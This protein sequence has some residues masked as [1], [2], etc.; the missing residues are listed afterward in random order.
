M[1]A[2]VRRWLCGRLDAALER[3]IDRVAG[4]ADVAAV[5]VM[6]DVHQ[7]RTVP[8]GVVVATR[9]LVYPDLVG[10]DIGCGL[11]AIRFR[12]AAA[13]MDREALEPL[14]D[15]LLTAVP[16]LK[17]AP[18]RAE[19]NRAALGQ[20]GSLS[21]DRLDRAA[22]RDG[23]Y[24][25]GTLGRGNHF[26]ELARGD[27]G[28]LWAVVHTGS[29]A[30]GQEITAHHLAR[31]AAAGGGDTARGAD[32]PPPLPAL[33]LDTPAGRDYFADMQWAC[34]YAAAN[35]A[36]I[37]NAV[38]DLL[39]GS[40][41]I[42]VEPESFVDSPHNTATAEE[43]A[44]EPLVVHRKS[45]NHAA[46]GRAGIVAGSMAIGSRITV[47]LGH[48]AA[49]ASSAHGAGRV[50]S[51]SV[52]AERVPARDL[53]SRMR[54][55]VFRR[56]WAA[57]LRDETPQAYRELHEVMQAQHELVRTVAVLVPILNDKRP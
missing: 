25:L 27:D 5:A 53:E 32:S 52:A 49:L 17:H 47:G 50:M 46:A 55:I 18:P 12:A 45:A 29:R 9:R 54:G 41:G 6:P 28:G 23:S 1:T 24:Q 51:R 19:A 21:C 22:A 43:H 33:D 30:I 37:L 44:A 13:D 4:Q 11:A 39:E 48:P 10:A 38:A 8:N 35:R 26:L 3:Q 36:T 40:R 20:L 42:G 2:A 16:T 14:L 31:L 34:R 56:E 7:G 15:R 57:R